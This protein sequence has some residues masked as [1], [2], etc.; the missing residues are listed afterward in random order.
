MVMAAAAQGVRME[1]NGP[2]RGAW[3][4]GRPEEGRARACPGRPYGARP[5]TAA[6]YFGLA[7]ELQ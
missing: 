7:Q 5:R 4:A 1:R 2:W 6:G 3:P